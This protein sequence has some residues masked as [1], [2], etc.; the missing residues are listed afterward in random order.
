MKITLLS[1]IVLLMSSSVF[2]ET[3]KDPNTSIKQIEKLSSTPI[4]TSKGFEF[5]RVKDGWKDK[6]SGLT[7]FDETD[8]DVNRYDA[9][10]Y[11]NKKGQMLPSEDDLKTAEQ[12]GIREIFKKDMNAGK[13]WSQ[14][15]VLDPHPTDYSIYFDALNGKTD[16]IGNRGMDHFFNARCVS[17]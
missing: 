8:K 5:V 16:S 14:S 9:G 10:E 4:K 13:F 3:C 2:A 6:T 7:W 15:V 17:K 12:H 11:C 1:F